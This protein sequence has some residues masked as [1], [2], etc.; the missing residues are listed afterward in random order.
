[1]DG[2]RYIINVPG[3]G[4]AFVATATRERAEPPGSDASE[5]VRGNEISASLTHII[6]R[7]KVIATLAGQTAQRRL[8]T[9][10]GPGG[11]GKTTIAA[12]I[13]EAVRA[14]YAD[15]VW[16]VE[17]ASLPSPDLVP[18]VLGTVLGISLPT[19]NPI[20]GLTAWL[21]DKHALIV[22]DNCEHVVSAV[23]T[24]AEAI[25]KSARRVCVLATSCEPLQAE[26]EWRH[27][28]APLEVP[29]SSTALAASDALRYS[30]IQLFN[31]RALL[32]SNELTIGER[33]IPT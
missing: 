24:L 21:R 30:A 5:A 3:R 15:G 20:S 16:F 27:R 12:A 28:L 26:G 23:A 19:G 6:G 17:L 10:V 8:L 25:L 33:E 4:Y 7:D 32:A 29:P 1:R 22:L 18:S 9:I 31:E 11:I 13:A 14:S 2:N